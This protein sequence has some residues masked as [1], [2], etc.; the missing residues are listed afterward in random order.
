MTIHS[1]EISVKTQGKYNVEDFQIFLHKFMQSDFWKSMEATIEDSPWHREANVATH[2]LMTMEA[3]RNRYIASSD[4]SVIQSTSQRD[5][6]LTMFALLF[7]DTGKPEAEQVKESADRGVY[8]SYAGHEQISARTFEDYAISHWNE[9]QHMLNP[10]DIYIITWM[11]EH[12]LPYGLAK[13][14]K[15]DALAKTLNTIFVHGTSSD[16]FFNMLKGDS[17]GRI[18]DKW[19]DN[20]SN[21]LDWISKMQMHLVQTWNTPSQPKEWVNN[22]LFMLAG[23]PGVGKSTVRENIKFVYKDNV[24]VHSLDDL[25]YEYASKFGNINK[26]THPDPLELYTAVFRYCNDDENQKL[27]SQYAEADLQAKLAMGIN[28]IIDNT[29]TS[30]KSRNAILQKAASRK[31]HT[32]AYYYPS[33]IQHLIDRNETRPDKKLPHSVLQKMHSSISLPTEGEFDC[34]RLM[35]PPHIIR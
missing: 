18:S 26:D 10:V 2:T 30:A 34:V 7:H 4:A 22:M 12:H 33:S 1:Q 6:M 17:F 23:P 28:I 3:E 11:I 13:K 29:N 24:C 16:A 8:R 32:E 14:H 25:R 35:F 27:F 15:V 31:M 21:V 5:H 20:Y 9:I 19:D